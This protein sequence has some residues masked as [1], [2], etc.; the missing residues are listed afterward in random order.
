MKRGM[1][2]YF[3]RFE[4]LIKEPKDGLMNAF[5]FLLATRNV[6]G[7]NL[8]QRI[9]DVLAMGKSATQTYKMKKGQRAYAKDEDMYTD[10]QKEL[11]FTKLHDFLVFFGF[12]EPRTP[13]EEAVGNKWAMF[14]YPECCKKNKAN[15]K[16]TIKYCGY[17]EA[18]EQALDYLEG[19]TRQQK[20]EKQWVV[21]NGR[22]F[23]VFHKTRNDIRFLDPYFPD[24]DEE[25]KLS[26]TEQAE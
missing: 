17:L 9:D 18:N 13:E 5:K 19:K 14:E 10:A 7:T 6:E 15:Q 1:P 21:K 12:F 16:S 4:I 22:T 2:M 11:L 20:A 26:D 25:N 8:E 3:T 24:Q 23:S